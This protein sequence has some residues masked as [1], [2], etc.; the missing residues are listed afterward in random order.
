MAAHPSSPADLE[1]I[2]KLKKQLQYAEL[3]IQVL[4][5]RLRKARIA[6]YG[7]GS[8]KLYTLTLWGKLTHFLEYGELELGNNL[9]E[10]SMRPVALGR[11]N[12]IHIGSPQAGPKIAAILSVVESCRRLKV[13]VR[14]YLH[15]TLPGLA[16][17]P[18]QRL[19]EHTPAAWA[20]H[21]Q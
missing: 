5:A 16:H 19:P 10:N 13:P 12:W 7:P 18:I 21:P 9:A 15:A 3:K 2:E 14:D 4:E 1:L 6:K 8:E 11:K 17:L 20:T